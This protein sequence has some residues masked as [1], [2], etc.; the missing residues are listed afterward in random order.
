MNAIVLWFAVAA[1][2]LAVELA[3]GTFYLLM[4]AL[5]CAVGGLVA[6]AGGGP[7]LQFVVGA[8]VG[9]VA[10]LVLR[11]VR[12]ARMVK[13]MPASADPNVILDIGEIVQVDAWTDGTAHVRYR[14][15]QWDAQLAPGAPAKT[16]PQVI[17]AVR[18]SVLVVIPSP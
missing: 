9:V 2:L 15:C 7:E 3:I 13:A 10:T 14:G 11:R 4:V 17:Q 12:S 5:G 8:A 6:L 1:G 18:G 16:G